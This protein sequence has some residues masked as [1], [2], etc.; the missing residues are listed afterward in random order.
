MAKDIVVKAT[1]KDD[2]STK[3][4]RMSGKVKS[5][6]GGIGKSSNSLIGSFTKLKGAIAVT[7]AVAAAVKFYKMTAAIASLIDENNKLAQSLGVTSQ[8]L[9]QLNHVAN[10]AGTSIQ[11]LVPGLKR[12]SVAAYDAANG[13]ERASKAF[14]QL[15]VNVKKTDGTMKDM[16]TL[17]NDTMIGLSKLENSTLKV[18]LSQ[19]LFGESGAKLIPV[20]NNGS[21]A[22]REQME[23]AKH[24]GV[25]FDEDLKEKAAS[26]NDQ[27]F[28]LKQSLIG[29]KAYFSGT[30]MMD[31]AESFY[32][33]AEGIAASRDF[34]EKIKD[35]GTEVEDTGDSFK[36]LA[37]AILG[38]TYAMTVLADSFMLGWN[39]IVNLTAT[40]IAAVVDT[41][42]YFKSKL[43]DLD[44]HKRLVIA[45]EAALMASSKS[46]GDYL[47]KS[48]E[49]TI[50]D[51]KVGSAKISKILN[52]IPGSYQFSEDDFMV[53]TNLDEYLKQLKE[54][55]TRLSEL[56][57]EQ[58]DLPGLEEFVIQLSVDIE[59]IDSSFDR[60]KAA[61]KAAGDFT[62]DE[63]SRIVYRYDRTSKNIYASTLEVKKSQEDYFATTKEMWRQTSEEA[64]TALDN[65]AKKAEE[66]WKVWYKIDNLEF[67]PST[68]PAVGGGG[69]GGGGDDA[70]DNSALIANIR[71][72]IGLYQELIDITSKQEEAAKTRV[73]VLGSYEDMIIGNMS[74]SYEQG[75]AA[76]DTKERRKIDQYKG[77]Y[78]EG[79]INEQ[80]FQ[81]IR[82]EIEKEA[83]DE[84]AALREETAMQVINGTAQVANQLTNIYKTIVQSRI[85]SI[86][87]E[88]DA[89]VASIEASRMSQMYK[90]RE[91]EKANKKADAE[92]KKEGKKLKAAAIV[93]ATIATATGAMNAFKALSQI[94]YVGPVLGAIAAAAV[95]ALGAVQIATIA[96]QNFAKGGIVQG[97]KGVDKVP[98]NLTDGEMV[99]NKEQQA[100]L[101]NMANGGGG[102]RSISA[103]DTYVT[104]NG[105]AD[106]DTVKLAMAESREKQIAAMRDLIIDM[107]YHGEF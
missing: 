97:E 3:L 107:K 75:M 96:S 48:L 11:E 31:F 33:M 17:I 49:N 63:M 73:D 19:K 53:A 59:R 14:A 5:D 26:F 24:L 71:E 27:L 100:R 66:F 36:W 61:I 55:Y 6:L 82:T 65:M 20:L 84:R 25:V 78:E 38:V 103:G 101:F 21:E 85:D 86:E 99:L 37:K 34:L 60:Y 46:I 35:V 92:R 50:T 47:K 74:N 4:S 52:N 62:D 8:Y 79:I 106:V 30:Y 22:I 9:D 87:K 93:E 70:P 102:G 95:I 76:I 32:Y 10:L 39:T 64:E 45:T 105:N 16:E 1:L 28:R 69:G 29:L 57:K 81:S 56:L 90:T 68:T 44:L 15:G 51:L 40:A 77:F 89:E 80:E 13:Q 91:I 94:P 7:L 58:P 72:Q 67:K 43:T 12:I 23:D 54:S 2:V 88:R 98:A 41:F 104:I 42:N 83:D 18:A